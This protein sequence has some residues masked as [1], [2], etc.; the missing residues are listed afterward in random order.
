M[1]KQ[2][3]FVP[4]QPFHDFYKSITRYPYPHTISA[5]PFFSSTSSGLRLKT[6]FGATCNEFAKMRIILAEL[7]NNAGGFNG[8][9]CSWKTNIASIGKT[10]LHR[11]PQNRRAISHFAH[12]NDHLK[13]SP[14]SRCFSRSFPRVQKNT[15]KIKKETITSIYV[16]RTPHLTI[17]P[18]T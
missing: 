8:I 5:S 13:N 11:Y 14:T 15:W 18:N 12:E 3:T 9:F 6:T 10:G 2:K 16:V 4:A 1:Q 17:S 7:R